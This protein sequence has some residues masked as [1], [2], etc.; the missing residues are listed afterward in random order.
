MWAHATITMASTVTVCTQ[1]PESFR[2]LV[3]YQPAVNQVMAS[4][5]TQT[6]ATVVDVIDLQKQRVRFLATRTLV[7]EFL[8][9]DP[10]LF[11]VTLPC[12]FAMLVGK[13]S[14]PFQRL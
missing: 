7:A 5:T 10:T 12:V 3:S 11:V 13:L 4:D 8:E 6:T 9:Y 14:V 2:E 1:E